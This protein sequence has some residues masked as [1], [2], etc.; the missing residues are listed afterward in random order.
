VEFHGAIV[1][2]MGELVGI[3][4]QETRDI[5]VDEQKLFNQLERR[6]GDLRHL[7]AAKRGEEM[8]PGYPSREEIDPDGP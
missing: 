5:T 2:R 6:V 8:A 3:A 7:I 4:K 1:D